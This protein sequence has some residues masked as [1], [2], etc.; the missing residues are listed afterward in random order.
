MRCANSTLNLSLESLR[1]DELQ[2]QS[3]STKILHFMF[4]SDL[5]NV[6]IHEIQQ[7]FISFISGLMAKLASI[8]EFLLLISRGYVLVNYFRALFI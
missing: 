6:R 7:F 2:D 3:L 8:H 4:M 5:K 1:I